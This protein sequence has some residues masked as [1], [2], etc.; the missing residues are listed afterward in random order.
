MLTFR[1][2]IP[3]VLERYQRRTVRL[4]G[5]LRAV[6]RELAGRASARLLPVLGI[7][8]GKDTAVR[9]LRGIPLP[10]RP[11]PEV[12]G[13]DDF[14]LRRSR[15]YATVLINAMTGARID[16]IPGRRTDGVAAWLR[17]HP[18]V[19]VVCRDGPAA[20]AQAV[21]DAIPE[22]VQVSDRWHLWHGLAEAVVKEVASHSTCWASATGLQN[23]P[24]AKTSL[25]RWR[26]V[27]DL[28]DHGIGLL[29][30]SRRLNPSLN[31]VKRVYA[32]R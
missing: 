17:Q 15:Y 32:C 1:E 11:I 26:Q 16:V 24:R 12:L 10:E 2:Q 9:V 28:V 14:A 7:I 4:T 29:D 13:V 31:T 25:Q 23:G 30:C 6:V 3:G 22:A 21:T 8:A 20:Y 27:H 5:Q 18:G 19:R